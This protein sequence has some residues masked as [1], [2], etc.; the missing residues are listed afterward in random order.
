MRFLVSDAANHSFPAEPIG[1]KPA[2]LIHASTA[3]IREFYSE[4]DDGRAFFSGAGGVEKLEKLSGAMEWIKN[5]PE[6]WAPVIDVRSPNPARFFFADGRHTF[7][8]LEKSGLTCIEIA[9]PQDR[10][11]EL[12]ALLSCDDT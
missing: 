5:N 3:K 6:V 1:C 7:V 2:V 10:S 9:V 11:Q 12:R 4:T 8:A